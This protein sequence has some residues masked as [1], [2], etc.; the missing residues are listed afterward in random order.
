MFVRDLRRALAGA[1]LAKMLQRLNNRAF[2]DLQNA[3][4][5]PPGRVTLP[6]GD[7]RNNSLDWRVPRSQ[8]ARGAPVADMMS[9]PMITPLTP[10]A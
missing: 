6:A 8:L 5:A 1:D 10:K 2:D 9:G 4:C 7:N 3:D